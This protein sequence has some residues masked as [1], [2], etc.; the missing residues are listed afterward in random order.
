MFIKKTVFF[1]LFLIYSVTIVA[2]TAK[3]VNVI[4]AG[5]LNTLL[6]P[7]EKSTV[8]DLTITGK[9]DARDF[10]CLRDQMTA[11][12]YLDLTTVEIVAYTGLGG[13]SDQTTSVSYPA[14]EIPQNAFSTTPAKTSLKTVFLPNTLVSI[15]VRAFNYCSGLMGINIPNSVTTINSNAFFY[16]S[17]MTNIILGN[18]VASIGNSAF[19]ECSGIT[20]ITIPNSVSSVGT[21][22]FYN[23]VKLANLKLG[24]GLVSIG[25]NAFLN[26]SALQNISVTA[27]T[28]PVISS[29][30]FSGTVNK[31]TCQL[32]VNAGLIPLYQSTNYWNSFSN[33]SEIVDANSFGISLQV[34]SNGS[35]SSNNVVL[36]NGTVMMVNSGDTK[37]FSIAPISGYEIA[38]V[39]YNNL[40]V[41]SQLINNT[42]TSPAINNNVTLSVT[43]KKI[44][45]QLQIKSAENG[46]ITQICEYGASPSYSFHPANGWT[47]NSILFNGNDVS[48]SLVNGIF[49]LPLLTTNSELIVTFSTT[50]TKAQ[51]YSN[52][53]IKVYTSE[54]EIIVEGLESGERIELY[55][56]KGQKL[57]T[58]AACEEKT[59]LHVNK[60][61]IY[62][63]K[64]PGKTFK[65]IL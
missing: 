26:C 37:T 14:N 41:K 47:I 34:G 20:S 50:A 59:S 52:S 65:I 19:F 46:S 17:G 27:S 30:S 49:T 9:L 62:L 44:L 29:T 13:T 22:S 2:Q 7:A 61:T 57:K 54:S 3:S 48:G 5:T 63:L 1:S 38:T 28:P 8:T 55:N 33:I 25:D 60:D 24:F 56:I 39:Y 45:I 11:L 4:S 31:S 10:K 16:C 51:E 42:F 40:D 53:K 6:T 18:S 21:Q 43:F 12:A 64:V 36:A 35:V 58:Q 23:C 15:G 32:K